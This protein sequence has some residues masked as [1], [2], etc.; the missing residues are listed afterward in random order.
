M[1]INLHFAVSLLIFVDLI[2]SVFIKPSKKSN[3]IHHIPLQLIERDSFAVQNRIDTRLY[4]C[5]RFSCTSTNFRENGRKAQGSLA[6]NS[7][8]EG[9]RSD[10]R[11]L[12]E[13]MRR[14]LGE[15]EDVFEDAESESKQ[16]LQGYGI[17]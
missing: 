11:S 12:L 10:D 14:S 8:R 2:D 17:I 6:R 13:Q 7:L 16:L 9:E 5:K 15:K 1:M 3:V 4:L